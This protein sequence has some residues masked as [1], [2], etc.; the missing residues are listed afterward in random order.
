MLMRLALTQFLGTRPM[1]ADCSS[2]ELIGI[3]QNLER[4]CHI[5]MRMYL[6]HKQ[7]SYSLVS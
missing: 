4:C 7:Q 3:Y 6:A 2:S 5:P 1:M